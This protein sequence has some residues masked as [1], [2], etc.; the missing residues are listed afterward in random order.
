MPVVSD[1]SI[2]K[3]S[4]EISVPLL[5]KKGKDVD[6][7]RELLFAPEMSTNRSGTITFIP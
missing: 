5:H 2:D 7:G 3:K 1:T 6:L 4:L